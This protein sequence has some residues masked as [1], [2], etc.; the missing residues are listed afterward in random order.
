[1][2]GHSKWSTI[3][4]KKGTV[5]AKRGKIF[6]KVIKEITVAARIGG[7]DAD[8]TP[9]LRLAVQKAKEVNMPQDN[10]I[11]AIKKGTGELEG[12]QYEEISYEG[13]GPG[14]GAIMME[15]ITDNRNRTVADIRHL[16]T[17]HGGNLGENGSVSWM[18]DKKGQIIIEKKLDNDDIIFEAAIQHGAD[19]FSVDENFYAVTTDQTVIM[20]VRDGLEDE[21][22]TI[23]SSEIEMIPKTLQKVNGQDAQNAL[24]LLEALDD[25][26]DI[27][28]V[29]SNFDFDENIINQD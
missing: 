9:R 11:R 12:I 4:H 1:M 23:R 15:I 29:Y 18:F 19:D 24:K 27:N 21:G 26:D 25:H 2:S 14:G 5:D 28:H 6:T 8:G 7:G 20:E 17:K 13:Y 16:L 3:K 22:F 10:V